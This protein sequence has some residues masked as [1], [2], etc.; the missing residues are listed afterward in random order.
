MS[1]IPEASLP[2]LDSVI[3]N[4]KAQTTLYKLEMLFSAYL[5]ILMILAE[6]Q[7]L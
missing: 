3:F 4:K 1:V 7:Y 6:T 2:L 5:P